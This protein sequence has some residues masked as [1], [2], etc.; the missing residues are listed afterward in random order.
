MNLFDL[1]QRCD[2]S[3]SCEG[4]AAAAMPVETATGQ[5]RAVRL[6]PGCVLRIANAHQLTSLSTLTEDLGWSVHVPR[7]GSPALP[8]VALRIGDRVLPLQTMIISGGS[9][10]HQIRFRWPIDIVKAD[11]FDLSIANPDSAAINVLCGPFVNMRDFLLPHAKGRGVEVGPGLRPHV[12][13]A[14]DVDVAYV[15]EQDPRE[16]LQLY[17]KTGEKPQLPEQSILDR[18][19]RASAVTLQEFERSSLDFVFS[20]HVFEH[21]P[22]P[23]AVLA[24]W[25]EALKPGG[26]V[27]GVLPDPRYTF[28]CRQPPTTLHEALEEERRG[29]HLIDPEK[30]ER[31]CRWTEPRH[32]PEDL[33]R[34]GYSIHVNFFTPESFRS[35]MRT[36]EDRRWFDRVFV[37]AALNH[38]DF[39]FALR[40]AKV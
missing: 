11:G 2:R 12:R 20:N 14:P 8:N 31:W 9:D 17:N 7:R 38:K 6:P 10:V 23:F 15:E 25:R 39:A 18:Y 3:I 33:I 24:N 27:L 4:D 22:N 29:G 36:L 34:R 1:V 19:R 37:Y 40:C 5:Q 21:L 13:P 35:A 28:D 26:M 32:T 30:Y 16:W